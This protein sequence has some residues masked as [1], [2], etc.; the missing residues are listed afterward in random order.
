MRFLEEVGLILAVEILLE[1]FFLGGKHFLLVDFHFQI[2]L[3][4]YD[5]HQKSS[6]DMIM[7]KF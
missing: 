1:N 2:S 3:N 7:I 5:S 4:I 6:S